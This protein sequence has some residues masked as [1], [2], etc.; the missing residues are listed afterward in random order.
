MDCSKMEHCPFF[1]DRMAKRP[2]TTEM[3][4][5]NYCKGDNRKCAPFAVSMA[6][7]AVPEDL[8]P[9]QEDRAREMITG[10]VPQ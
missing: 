4:K 9:G 5:A 3:M 10:S 1:G 6:G 2:A 7:L 8:Y